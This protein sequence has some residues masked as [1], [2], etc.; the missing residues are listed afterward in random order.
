MKTNAEWYLRNGLVETAFM[1]CERIS[2]GIYCQSI[3][4]H[5]IVDFIQQFRL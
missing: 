5:A 4:K 3:S 1:I 2:V